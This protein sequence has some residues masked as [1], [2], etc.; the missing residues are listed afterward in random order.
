M[1][2]FNFNRFFAAI[3]AI[4]WVSMLPACA[5]F[6]SPSKSENEVVAGAPAAE[7]PPAVATAPPAVT[8]VAVSTAPTTPAAPNRYMQFVKEKKPL[9]EM[10]MKS[11]PAC[12]TMAT[13]FGRASPN[14][15]ASSAVRCN[16]KSFSAVLPVSAVMKNPKTKNNYVARFR[17][18]EFCTR[19]IDTLTQN[20]KSTVVRNCVDRK[21]T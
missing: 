4:A 15:R 2:N 16:P 6:Q 17:S 7:P 9:F 18:K 10:D 3:L 19:V 20:G 8:P 1:G 14:E 21:K 13:S 5:L 12:Q 11:E